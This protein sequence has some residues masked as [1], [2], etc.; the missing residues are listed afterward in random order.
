MRLLGG[1]MI[2]AGCLGMGLWYREYFMGRLNCLRDLQRIQEML[3]S[4]IRYGRSTLPECCNSIAGRLQEP[5]SSCFGI[6]YERMRENGGVKF[7]QVFREEIG[8]CLDK[9]PLTE[10]DRK[11]FLSLF[12]EGG[13]EEERMQ[14]HTIEQN[15][16][17]LQ[18]TVSEL[19]RENKDKCRMAV[20]L[21]A[22]SGLLLVIVL[23]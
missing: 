6:I 19:E 12:S 10:A 9:L 11:C 1:I 22:M 7:G 8:P 5:Y 3:I 2:L 21:G 20:G 16:E 18:K 14:I 13:F 23:I 4:E 17:M 15:K